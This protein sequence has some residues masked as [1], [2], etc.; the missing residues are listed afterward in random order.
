M[1]ASVAA[2]DSP[3]SEPLALDVN[4]LSTSGIPS[5]MSDETLKVNI[6][7]DDFNEEIPADTPNINEFDES[8]RDSSEKYR[9]QPLQEVKAEGVYLWQLTKQ[10]LLRPRA[11]GCLIG[12][13]NT[14]VIGTVAYFG[15]VKWDL[16]RWNKRVVM[17]VSI[18][19]VA[20]FG[21]ERYIVERERR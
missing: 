3:P 13:V 20:L 14:A 10:Y 19:L 15:Y 18:G 17:S 4:P 6:V 16:P 21:L 12:L 11:A 5:E 7:P 9:R 8:A 1:H 2:H